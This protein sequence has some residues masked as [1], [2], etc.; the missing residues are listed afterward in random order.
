MQILTATVSH[1]TPALRDRASWV[2]GFGGTA[3]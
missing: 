2:E 1:P 3:Y